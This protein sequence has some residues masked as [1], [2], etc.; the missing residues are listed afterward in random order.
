LIVSLLIIVLSVWIGGFVAY[1][2]RSRT[3]WWKIWRPLI[4]SFG[5]A[6]LLGITV[7]HLMPE[8]YA[9]GE[10]FVRLG[11]FILLGFLIQIVLETLTGGLEHGHIH[12]EKSKKGFLWTMAVPVFI[13]LSI[14]AL[15]E[16]LPLNGLHNHDHQHPYVWGMFVHKFPAA[17]SLMAYLLGSGLQINRAWFILFVFSLM[18]PLGYFLGFWID[19]DNLNLN[20]YPIFVSVVIG[21]F[22]HIATIVLFEFNN[23]EGHHFSYRRLALILI[24]ILLAAFI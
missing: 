1:Y 4:L 18:T 10:N 2:L 23:P 8:I 22:L 17:F 12:V 9:S 7:L 16:G 11:Y 24:G 5:G 19:L 15:I 13:G 20:L 3:E 21:S 6:F 14:H